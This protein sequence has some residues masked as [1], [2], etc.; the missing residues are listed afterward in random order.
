M[1]AGWRLQ[2][3]S[4]KGHFILSKRGSQVVLSIPNHKEVKGSLLKGQIRKSGLSIAE[5]LKYLD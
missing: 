3:L 4:K 1:K 2:R 5:F